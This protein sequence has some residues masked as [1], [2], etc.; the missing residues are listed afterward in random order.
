M[1][2]HSAMVMESQ[3]TK[4]NHVNIYKIAADKVHIKSMYIKIAADEDFREGYV[5]IRNTI[6]CYV[7][8]RCH[9]FNYAMYSRE[10]MM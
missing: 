8:T 4:K 6:S 9:I 3:L 5:L 1:Q 2:I 7:I 10:T